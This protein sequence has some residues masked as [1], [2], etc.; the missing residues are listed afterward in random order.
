VLIVRTYE[1]KSVAAVTV[2]PDPT[3]ND[4]QVNVQLKENSFV[5][6]KVTDNNGSEVMKKTAHGALGANNYNLEGTSRLQPGMYLL[7]VII[8]SNERLT[9]KLAKS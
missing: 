1:T 3:V 7:E 5:V 8:N 2:T 6:M 4:I 9:M